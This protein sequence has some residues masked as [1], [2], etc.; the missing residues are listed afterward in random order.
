MSGRPG[1]RGSGLFL[2]LSRIKRV[3][4]VEKIPQLSSLIPTFIGHAKG[5]SFFDKFSVMNGF[6]LRAD[7]R[8]PIRFLFY[9]D[10]APQTCQAFALLLPFTRIFVHA[11]TSGQEVWTDDSPPLDVIQE[12][13]S[14]FTEP[15]EAVI[16]PCRPLRTRT[17][18]C[19]GIYYGEGKGLD[20]CNIFAKVF[21]EDLGKLRD[22]GMAIWT[23]GAREIHFEGLP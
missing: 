2:L 22:L 11:R 5:S 17:A 10:S 12:N 4:I 18:N 8:A 6:T 7:N 1:V 3:R 13:A 16:G 21:D 19:M 23:Q 14:I 20:A 9:L 15:G